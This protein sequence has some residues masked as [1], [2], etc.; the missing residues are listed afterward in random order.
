M[1]ASDLVALLRLDIG[2]TAGEMLG[3][4]YLTRCV[5]RA[6][7]AVNKDFGTSF[8]VNAGEITPDPSGEQQEY[9]LLKAHINVCSLMRS[10]TANNFSFQSGDKQVDKTKQPS[11]WA[12]LQGDLEKDYKERAKSAAPDSGGVVDDPDNGIMAAPAIRPAIYE[13][14]YVE[15]PDVALK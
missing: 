5:T 9:L 15:E 11:F 2:D 3:D 1:L 8:A 12:D 6:V 10:I 13:H 14:G 7:F 4:E